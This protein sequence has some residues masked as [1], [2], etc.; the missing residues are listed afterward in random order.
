MRDTRH[1]WSTT[2]IAVAVASDLSFWSF[3]FIAKTLRTNECSQSEIILFC[4]STSFS[5]LA[6]PIGKHGLWAAEPDLIFHTLSWCWEPVPMAGRPHTKGP[7]I[8]KHGSTSNVHAHRR[9]LCTAMVPCWC[10]AP[11]PSRSSASAQ[12]PC[13]SVSLAH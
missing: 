13:D 3:L 10:V 2:T 5:C 9:A 11:V 8:L 6:W 4:L 1:Q 12:N 7:P